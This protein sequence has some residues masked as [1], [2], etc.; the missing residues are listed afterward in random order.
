MPVLVVALVG[1]VTL[2][3]V[4]FLLSYAGLAEA[5]GW[6]RVPA[7]LS[8]AVPVTIDGSIL[9]YTIAAWVFRARGESARLAWGALTLFAVLSVVA[10]SVHAWGDSPA[11]LRTVLG[12]VIAGL[13]PVAV[14]LTTHTIGRLIIAPPDATVADA[15]LEPE[16]PLADVVETPPW[17]LV[18]VPEVEPE[19]RDARIVALRAENLSYAAIAETV[20]VSKTTVSR[21]LERT[22]A[23]ASEVVAA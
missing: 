5:A 16:P 10:N 15:V 13:A 3:A 12:M 6:A 22:A 1:T 19:D 20:G 17:S 4:S 11:A 14:V 23:A 9:V 18:E 21:V 8:W 7:G 2:F